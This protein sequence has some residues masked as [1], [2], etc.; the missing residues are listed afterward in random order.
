MLISLIIVV[1]TE[2]CGYLAMPAVYI[3]IVRFVHL[4]VVSMGVVIF[5]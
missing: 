3:I 4:A 5:E 1:V 2:T